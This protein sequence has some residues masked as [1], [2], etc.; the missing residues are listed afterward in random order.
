MYR[1]WNGS[2]ADDSVVWDKGSHVAYDPARIAKIDHDGTHFKM[3]ARH[4][5]HPSPQRT[6]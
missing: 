5:M 3:H 4:Q 6:P 2:W 1:L